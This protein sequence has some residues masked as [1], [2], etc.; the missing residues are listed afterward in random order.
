MEDELRFELAF[1]MTDEDFIGFIEHVSLTGE[2]YLMQMKRTRRLI[3]AVCIVFG[4]LWALMTRDAAAIAIMSFALTV[5]AVISWFTWPARW[6]A[7]IRGQAVRQA[8]M[9][10]RRTLVGPKRY[11]IDAEGLRFSG[12]YSGGYAQWPAIMRVS[13]DDKAIY[14]HVAQASAHILPRRAFGSAEEFAELALRAE[15]W[16]ACYPTRVTAP[17]TPE[18]PAANDFTP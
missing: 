5:A 16:R 2:F 15:E 17:A 1:E 10:N 11:T 12:L 7:T 4:L 6:R 8:G 14:L 18:E 9:E 13:S 3:V